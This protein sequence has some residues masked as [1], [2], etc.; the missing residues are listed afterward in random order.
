MT[1][2]GHTLTEELAQLAGELAHHV[3]S[4]LAMVEANMGALERL[5]DTLGQHDPAA[6]AELKEILEDVRAGLLQLGGVARR[7]STL[8]YRLTHDDHLLGAPFSNF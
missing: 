7:V 4:P 3:N 1:P 8:S 5:C 6:H 2:H